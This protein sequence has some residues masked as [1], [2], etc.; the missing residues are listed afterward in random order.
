MKRIQLVLAALAIVVT[1]LVAF[2]GP[3]MAQNLDCRD[4]RGDLVRC[5]GE[6]YAP[7]NNDSYDYND[8]PPFY[9]SPFSN[10]Y[11][12]EDYEDYDDYLD[13]LE[14]YLDDLEDNSSSWAWND[15]YNNW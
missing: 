8:Y 6:L 11:N 5:D 1:S 7:Y 9:N 15:Y 10:D 12:Y 3:A 14:D 2:S 4:A 13:D